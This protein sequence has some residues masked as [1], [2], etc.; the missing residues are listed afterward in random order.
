MNMKFPALAALVASMLSLAASG[1]TSDRVQSRV[2]TNQAVQSQT[3]PVRVPAA[4]SSRLRAAAP[5]DATVESVARD[6]QRI[7]V[8]CATE[9]ESDEFMTQWLSYVKRHQVAESNLE[10]VVDD[11][12]RRAGAYQAEHR[13]GPRTNRMITIMTSTSRKMHEA[14]KNAIN[15]IR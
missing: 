14:A 11:I 10:A 6:L 13:S 3:E 12:I 2:I 1:Q 15:N 4:T 9:P 5:A 8:L 7:V